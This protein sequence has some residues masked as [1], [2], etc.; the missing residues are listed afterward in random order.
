MECFIWNAHQNFANIVGVGRGDGTVY[1]CV[2]AANQTG[3]GQPGTSVTFTLTQN[4][5]STGDAPSAKLHVVH[6]V[7]VNANG[8]VTAVVGNVSSTCQ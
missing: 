7:T 2:G 3:T 6:H 1:N 4:L 8:D 5:I